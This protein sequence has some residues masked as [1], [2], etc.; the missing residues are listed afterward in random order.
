[1]PI[2]KNEEAPTFSKA[3]N[4]RE[5]DP[6]IDRI[7]IAADTDE[8]GEHE[9]G[10]VTLYLDIGKAYTFQLDGDCCST[11][12]FTPEAELA[13]KELIGAKILAVEHRGGAS[14]GST[15]GTYEA[16]DRLPLD[17]KERSKE[18]E[19]KY[20][21]SDCDSW[22]FIVFTTD[23]GH[24]TIDWRNCSNGYYDGSCTVFEADPLPTPAHDLALDGRAEEAL[25]LRDLVAAAPLEKR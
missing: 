19:A 13:F 10:K 12:Y 15:W 14:V 4:D 1:M 24:V 6:L 20:P 18:L 3:A 25:K 23:K 5:F 21:P 9:Q 17:A 7:V 2:G 8:K 22:H 11:S 16:D